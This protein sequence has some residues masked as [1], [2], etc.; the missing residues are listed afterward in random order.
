[1][2]TSGR[3]KKSVPDIFSM[4][5]TFGICLVAAIDLVRYA[6]LGSGAAFLTMLVVEAAFVC[7]A[8]A[9]WRGRCH[10]LLALV[11][12]AGVV[13]YFYM[14]NAETTQ[15]NLTLLIQAALAAVGAVGGTVWCIAGRLSPRRAAAL[16]LIPVL[17]LAVIC[18]GVWGGCT[19]ADDKKTLAEPCLWS[20]PDKY[21]AENCPE[22]GRVEE[23]YY[24]TKAYATDGRSV[25][26][27]ALVYL[28]YG[29]SEAEEYDI[30]YLLHGTGDDEEY[31][32]RTYSYNKTMLDN[33]IYYGEVQPLI[34]VTP[35]WYVE[36]DCEGN[37]DPLTYSFKQELR[38]DLM[39]AAESAYS[40]Y[41]ETCDR[42]GFAA[43]RSHRAFAGLSRGAVTTLH[44]VF[45]GC[46][47]LF[48]RFGTFSGSRTPVEYFAE[49]IQ[50]EECKDLS[51]DYWYVASGTFDFALAGQLQ[52]YKAVLAA[53]PR[54]QEG[55]NTSLDVFP[56]RYH[57]MGS[58]HLALYNFLLKAF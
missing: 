18:G 38:S 51:I 46:L 33:L 49:H 2:Q 8:L 3:I 52:D 27:R 50:S 9:A 4:A 54:L 26:K 34:V 6:V 57:S 15:F 31:W 44:S 29:Y 36:D 45:N 43:S 30:L 32:L 24:T 41:A 17:A 22:Q 58:W 28:P 19:A 14:N 37:L 16:L 23:L 11:A 7:V 1:M 39:P 53:E 13:L 12:A 40:T 55:V 48:S 5:V 21:D 25:E 47:D 35:T 20:V 10:A 56:M 42:E